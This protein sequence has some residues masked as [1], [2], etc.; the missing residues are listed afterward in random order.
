MFD[1]NIDPLKRKQALHRF[2]KTLVAFLLIGF[3]SQAYGVGRVGVGFSTV[4][5]GRQVPALGLGLDLPNGWVASAMLAGTR[6]KAYYTSGFTLNALYVRDWGK[7][8]F[9][10]LEVGFGG[11]GYYGEKGIYTQ[12]DQSGSLTN[13]KKDRDHGF[14]PSFRV[15]FKPI[16]NMHIS[17]EY[18]M[19]IGSSLFSN[20]W[21]DVGMGSIG[22]DL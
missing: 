18:M 19:G 12:V 5:S 7:F 22:V 21:Q 9:G 20:A 10:N 6:T 16:K 1:K 8:W 13:L 11:G 2:I 15:A 17:V 4:T 14:G 3:T